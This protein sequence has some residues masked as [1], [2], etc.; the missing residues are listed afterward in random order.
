MQSRQQALRTRAAAACERQGTR[1]SGE[2]RER[3]RDSREK[4]V[5][6]GDG[7]SVCAIFRGQ[8]S[9]AQG[10]ILRPII[11]AA[12]AASISC[13]DLYSR[14]VKRLKTPPAPF[15][16]HASD[17][18]SLQCTSYEG[19]AKRNTNPCSVR[20][21]SMQQAHSRD[22]RMLR[23][24]M[25]DQSE[26]DRA[27]RITVCVEPDGGFAKNKKVSFASSGK[28]LSCVPAIWYLYGASVC[29]ALQ[30]ATHCMSWHFK[31]SFAER[32]ELDN[33]G[34]VCQLSGGCSAFA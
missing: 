15:E 17:E 21:P 6:G 34:R 12:P 27:G 5:F 26:L 19:W 20:S 30:S 2:A 28:A 10:L 11:N 9:Q 18:E 24:D 16:L 13:A 25:D 3:E 23:R 7:H 22:S 29:A 4:N 1:L 14:R 8:P 33:A 32:Q 31:G